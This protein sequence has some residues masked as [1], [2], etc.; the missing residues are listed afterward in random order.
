MLFNSP[1]FLF[2]FFPL[3]YFLYRLVPNSF[4][5]GILLA[6]SLLFYAWAEPIFVFWA[7]GSAFLDWTLGEVI[8]RNFEQ[9]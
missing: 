2:L 8:S 9:Q 4:R 3:L 5:N 6:A 7:L 1:L